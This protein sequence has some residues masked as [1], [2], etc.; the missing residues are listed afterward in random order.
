MAFEKIGPEREACLQ[1]ENFVLNALQGNG[2]I[3]SAEIEGDKE[4]GD[5]RG[6]FVMRK[7]QKPVMTAEEHH[8]KWM[9]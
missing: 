6:T 3:I 8:P 5:V 2:E 4:T 1:F 9:A 7:R